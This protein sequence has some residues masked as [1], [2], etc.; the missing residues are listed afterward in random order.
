MA[1]IGLFFWIF[2]IFFGLFLLF[3]DL[4][5][6]NLILRFFEI[7]EF[8]VFVYNIWIFGFS[9]FCYQAYYWTPKIA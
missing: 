5:Q 7:F 1:L 4:K 2:W 9:D 6:K 3:L 8:L